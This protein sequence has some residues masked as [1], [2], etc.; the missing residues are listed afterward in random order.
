MT[1]DEV[2]KATNTDE[3]LILLRKIPTSG[4]KHLPKTL[5]AYKRLFP[6]LSVSREGIVRFQ[7]AQDPLT[8][9]T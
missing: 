7:R 6:E 5:N 8:E 4:A 2:A 9:N 3:D 1:V